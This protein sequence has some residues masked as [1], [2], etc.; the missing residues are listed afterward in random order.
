LCSGKLAQA[1]FFAVL[2]IWFVVRGGESNPAGL[3]AMPQPVQDLCRKAD[4]G[5]AIQRAILVFLILEFVF[6]VIASFRDQ[7]N[8]SMNIYRSRV[9]LDMLGSFSYFWFLQSSFIGVTCLILPLSSWLPSPASC[10]SKG[11]KKATLS[12]TAC[13]VP[14]VARLGIISFM[15]QTHHGVD[16]HC[17]SRL[18]SHLL[19]SSSSL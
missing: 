15:I 16:S 1:L 12:S 6:N 17:G 8:C 2:N 4:V 9:C 11:S 18:F 10:A 5:L 14:R 19:W 13:L 3:Q 7:D